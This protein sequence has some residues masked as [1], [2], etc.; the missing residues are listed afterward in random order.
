MLVIAVRM[1]IDASIGETAAIGLVPVCAGRA[2]QRPQRQ[3]VSPVSAPQPARKNE[4]SSLP[5]REKKTFDGMASSLVSMPARE[6]AATAWA[7]FSSLM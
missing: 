3:L 4:N 1:S 2:D 6:E 5:A 7:T